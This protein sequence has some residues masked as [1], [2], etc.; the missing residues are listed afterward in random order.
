MLPTTSV[1][2]GKVFDDERGGPIALKGGEGLTPSFPVALASRRH[3]RSPTQAERYG[4]YHLT[5][6][7]QLHC[8]AEQMLKVE[9]IMGVMQKM[10]TKMVCKQFQAVARKLR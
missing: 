3:S 1:H 9:R 5:A 7:L 6:F 4:K 8:L 10:L 2:T